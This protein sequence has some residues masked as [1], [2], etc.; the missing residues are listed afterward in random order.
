MAGTGIMKFSVTLV[1]TV[2]FAAVLAA[3][4]YLEA[5]REPPARGGT[6]EVSEKL[7]PLEEDDEVTRIDI[8]DEESHEK[9]VLEKEG[10]RWRITEPISYPAEALIID[11]LVGALK[12]S[13]KARRLAPEKDWDE[14]GLENPRFRI[15]I[16]TRSKRLKRVLL[17]GDASPLGRF[18][19]ARWAGEQEYFLLDENLKLS[20]DRTLYSLREKRIFRTPLKDLEKMKIKTAKNEYEFVKQEGGWVWTEPIPL[21][22]AEISK[23]YEDELLTQIRDLYIKE[24][25]DGETRTDAELG[26]TSGANY[27]AVWGAGAPNPEILLLGKAE[28][29]K[30]GFYAR[31]KDEPISFLISRRNIRRL[32]QTVE[33]VATESLTGKSRNAV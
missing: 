8:D 3:Y 32:L 25:L 33:A 29:V 31:R 4:L 1:F 21:L 24:F 18:V 14:Y 22:G 5:E 26:L 30:D 27:V 10:D 11:G 20:F 9:I 13:F 17:F 19:Y 2:L 7:L 23:K 15:G 12:V 16:E 6:R 28:E